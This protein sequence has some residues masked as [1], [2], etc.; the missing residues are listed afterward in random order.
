MAACTGEREALSKAQFR[1]GV[2]LRHLHNVLKEVQEAGR[3]E[4]GARTGDEQASQNGRQLQVEHSPEDVL[5][6]DFTVELSLARSLGVLDDVGVPRPR[7]D[8]CREQ[9]ADEM[10]MNKEASFRTPSPRPR[11]AAASPSRTGERRTAPVTASH[12][13]GLK[14][15][16]KELVEL[17]A[18]VDAAYL[19][20]IVGDQL[21]DIKELVSYSSKK[22]ILTG[23]RKNWY[24]YST[25]RKDKKRNFL[26]PAAAGAGVVM[27]PSPGR[28]KFSEIMRSKKAFFFC[29]IARGAFLGDGGGGPLAEG[30]GGPG[31]P[32]PGLSSLASD[33][34]TDAVSLGPGVPP[35]P[36]RPPL[37]GEKENESLDDDAGPRPRS[38]EQYVQNMS[39]GGGVKKKDVDEW[40]E[41]VWG[42]WPQRP[43]KGKLPPAEYAEREEFRAGF[44]NLN[45]LWRGVELQKAVRGAERVR[46]AGAAAKARA[47]D[48]PPGELFAMEEGAKN[49][50][51]ERIWA[52]EL[53]EMKEMTGISEV[54]QPA[55]IRV[56][57]DVD[58]VRRAQLLR[59]EADRLL[60]NDTDS[61]RNKRHFSNGVLPLPYGAA[62]DAVAAASQSF[63][64]RNPDRA[65][66]ITIGDRK[67]KETRTPSLCHHL[68]EHF[69]AEYMAALHGTASLY[70]SG[71]ID[72]HDNH[73]AL[74]QTRSTLPKVRFVKRPLAEL[75]WATENWQVMV[76][77]LWGAIKHFLLHEILTPRVVKV[78][79]T[80]EIRGKTRAQ[81]FA[82][83]PEH[84][85]ETSSQISARVQR[86]F[87]S[88]T[89]TV[90]KIVLFVSVLY[91]NGIHT[92]DE[93]AQV[94]AHDLVETEAERIVSREVVAHEDEAEQA[95]AVEGRGAAAK[96]VT[97][98]GPLLPLPEAAVG[99]S[100]G[101][102]HLSPKWRFLV[103]WGKLRGGL[104]REAYQFC[105]SVWANAR[106]GH[107]LKQLMALYPEACAKLYRKFGKHKM[108]A[109]TAVA[110]AWTPTSRDL[111]SESAATYAARSKRS[112]IGL[113]KAFV[114]GVNVAQQLQPMAAGDAAVIV[115]LEAPEAALVR[116][117]TEFGGST[118]PPTS[119]AA[120][121][122]GA[123]GPVGDGGQAAVVDEEAVKKEFVTAI[124]QNLPPTPS[125]MS[126]LWRGFGDLF[127]SK[128]S[129][130]HMLETG[131]GAE[132][133][134]QL[135]DVDPKTD[136]SS[137]GG[138]RDAANRI[139]KRYDAR[140]AT[141]HGEGQ[142]QSESKAAVLV[143]TLYRTCL[144]QKSLYLKT[145]VFH[146]LF[147]NNHAVASVKGKLLR[148]IAA[149]SGG[150]G[151][152]RGEQ[153][154]EEPPETRNEGRGSGDA[155]DAPCDDEAAI[156]QGSEDGASA[157][158]AGSAV[159][160]AGGAATG[161][162][163]K[164]AE[165]NKGFF[166][167]T[168]P[169][170][171]G[172]AFLGVERRALTDKT[173]IVAHGKKRKTK[174]LTADDV[175]DEEVS[176]TGESAE[177][178]AEP[179]G[180]RSP[181]QK[182]RLALA[183]AFGELTKRLLDE[184]AKTQ[185]TWTLLDDGLNAANLKRFY[186]EALLMQERAFPDHARIAAAWNSRIAGDAAL[187]SIALK[188]AI[189]A[190]NSITAEDGK[191]ARSSDSEVIGEGEVAGDV[192]ISDGGFS[193]SE[194]RIFLNKMS[195]S[196]CVA[197]EI[198]P[199]PSRDSQSDGLSNALTEKPF[200]SLEEARLFIQNQGGCSHLLYSPFAEA[201][202]YANA[203]LWVDMGQAKR[204]KEQCEGCTCTDDA[205]E[206]ARQGLGRAEKKEVIDEEIAAYK[207]GVWQ[208]DAGTMAVGDI[209][210]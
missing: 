6:H 109:L 93:D 206:V 49:L 193:F 138:L 209:Y 164:K 47:E 159:T 19:R 72:S 198:A 157:L 188:E 204:A 24:N 56:G 142:A 40:C 179:A 141:D 5:D 91:A 103:A 67:T 42:K 111:C 122:D 39:S 89:G 100:A 136:L 169:E 167:F 26:R 113:R 125:V 97:I 30:A 110:D 46:K 31:G 133:A 202:G 152:L 126:R 178:E 115:D 29:G 33:V 65:R 156:I 189:V 131:P 150:E 180:L 172:A 196:A 210:S 12:A 186:G 139:V 171:G 55:E 199:N 28:R 147:Q 10:M 184:A 76:G 121:G 168:V 27:A 197:V 208:P 41:N 207:D 71:L 54:L 35:A 205:G 45:E 107:D 16:I 129:L 128:G 120:G 36:P 22:C 114:W 69:G 108:W 175:E 99:V 38:A 50:E 1:L 185:K 74:L 90:Q 70:L 155:D 140:S 82:E 14:I 135:F 190:G 78:A 165:D 58:E 191:W 68:Y 9:D 84:G 101:H 187:E 201:L 51:R 85:S 88:V 60:E 44:R 118:A 117:K 112:K 158:G 8:S 81:L 80:D 53:A 13:P 79:V 23:G 66:K 59:D 127:S 104:E 203:E 73:H 94:F 146:N 83:R 192:D 160:D 75:W 177:P 145:K 183:K 25:K 18:S 151:V 149:G 161:A 34:Q 61:E 106:E 119:L 200:P 144:Q 62:A 3:R 96:L 134:R 170:R 63:E 105:D 162:E 102:G 48:K 92:A 181:A 37:V 7:G 15:N 148:R 21:S 20:G 137:C 4:A 116:V 57:G 43:V 124:T 98:K 154:A 176:E 173:D 52:E 130:E 64:K 123:T 77:G 17:G 2:A 153:N 32:D 195:T 143:N 174:N 132:H 166:M 95:A 163:P 194:Y 87:A 182:Q 86:E 11:A